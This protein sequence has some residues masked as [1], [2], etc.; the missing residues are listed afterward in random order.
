MRKAA[1]VSIMIV[2]FI[3]ITF[4]S[5]DQPCPLDIIPDSISLEGAV[6]QKAYSN[7]DSKS[8]KNN[9]HSTFENPEAN[10]SNSVGQKTGTGASIIYNILGESNNLS[11]EEQK[12]MKKWRSDMQKFAR[13]NPGLVFI[14]GFTSEKTVCL[15]FDDGPDEVI[16]PHILNILRRY[17]V[18][19]SFFCVGNKLDQHPDIVQRAYQDGHLVLSHSWS[20]QQFNLMERQEIKSEI[21]LTE[22]K[23]YEL[24]G[25][26]PV[27]IRPPFGE[28]DGRVADIIKSRGGKVILWSIDTLD[29]SQREKGNIV[30]NVTEHIRPGD[31]ILMHCNGDKTETVNALPAIITALRQ[32]GYQFVDLG[33]M[34]QMKPYQ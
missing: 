10:D 21:Q 29:W 25:Q 31:I 5:L 18:K 19:A 14:N 11:E 28:I 1:G 13:D 15:T 26:R 9:D 23:I 33:E 34:L 3:L 24:I 32:K 7:N 2:C 30:H 16:T 8:L 12:N 6:D 27:F 22:D 4:M 20:H 17:H